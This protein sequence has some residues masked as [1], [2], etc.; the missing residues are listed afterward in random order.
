MW[1]TEAA[2]PNGKWSRAGE[3]QDGTDGETG[4]A[5]PL[6]GGMRALPASRRVEGAESEKSW[7]WSQARAAWSNRRKRNQCASGAPNGC[8]LSDDLWRVCAWQK[9]NGVAARGRSLERRVRRGGREQ[10]GRCCK[11]ERRCHSSAARAGQPTA[12]RPRHA[13]TNGRARDGQPAGGM[14]ALPAGER[15]VGA[16]RPENACDGREAK[17]PS[18]WHAEQAL[19]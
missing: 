13:T 8:K 9:E 15:V 6:A 5:R 17:G 18:A 1:S 7:R 14:R 11:G 2:R 12:E 19:K 4:T 16:V 10:G 3:K